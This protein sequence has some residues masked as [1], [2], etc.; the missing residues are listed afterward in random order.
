MGPVSNSYK[1]A[2]ETI[3]M[4]AETCERILRLHR[5][6]NISN[7]VFLRSFIFRLGGM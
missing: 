5:P 4:F 6:K 7:R 3:E 2:R 1:L